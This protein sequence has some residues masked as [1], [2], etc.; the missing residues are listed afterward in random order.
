MLITKIKTSDL[1]DLFINLLILKNFG[2]DVSYFFFFLFET[3]NHFFQKFTGIERDGRNHYDS[4]TG[5]KLF[6]LK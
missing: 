1:I 6:S 5:Y 2:N 4:I 3:N